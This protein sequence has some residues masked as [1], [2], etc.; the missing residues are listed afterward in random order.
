MRMPLSKFLYGLLP[1]S[2]RP[3]PI[4]EKEMRMRMFATVGDH[5]PCLLAVVDR[6]QETMESDF[7]VAIDPT[8]TDLDRLRAC[9]GLRVSY[10]NL[11]FIEKERTEAK[12]WKEKKDGDK[13]Q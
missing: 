1:E 10:W 2:L 12:A 5:D 11:H 7:N 8:R 3:R 9:E 13:T 6:L 4:L